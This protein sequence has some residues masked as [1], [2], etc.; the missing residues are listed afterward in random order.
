MLSTCQ[1][2][3][4]NYGEGGGRL[5]YRTGVGGGGGGGD[6]RKE[7]GNNKNPCIDLSENRK[8]GRNTVNDFGLLNL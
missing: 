2:L 7:N 4:I 1:G 3:V 6:L 5:Q 8:F